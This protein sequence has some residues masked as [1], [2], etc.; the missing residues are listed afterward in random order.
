M[1]L[2][3]QTLGI[4]TTK[5]IELMNL[6]KVHKNI[7]FLRLNEH[8]RLTKL[9]EE[10]KDVNPNLINLFERFNASNEFMKFFKRRN[11]KKSEI[12]HDSTGEE[13]KYLEKLKECLRQYFLI[14]VSTLIPEDK[15]KGK[16]ELVKKFFK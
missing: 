5:E 3:S 14:E 11:I 10:K 4:L 12:Y 13:Q 15:K 6:L 1:I 9:C 2:N 7:N 16:I 8:Y